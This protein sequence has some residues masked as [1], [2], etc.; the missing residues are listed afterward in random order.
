MVWERAQGIVQVLWWCLYQL[1]L[2]ENLW[3]CRGCN[4][5]LSG[6]FA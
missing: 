6:S 5:L 4:Y 3:T 1:S 2:K